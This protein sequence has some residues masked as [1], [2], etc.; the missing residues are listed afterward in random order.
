M[1][2]KNY[3]IIANCNFEAGDP[4]L[5][6]VEAVRCHWADDKDLISALDNLEGVLTTNA[7][8]GDVQSIECCNDAESAVQ[9]A[10]A[11]VEDEAYEAEKS[12]QVDW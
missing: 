10:W 8:R 4:I 5:C 3:Q 7:L 11:E 6:A 9:R 12:S 1:S 2:I